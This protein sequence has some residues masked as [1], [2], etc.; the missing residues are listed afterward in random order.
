MTPD[1]FEATVGAPLETFHHQC[2]AASIAL[3]KS[4]V[5]GDGARVARGTCPGVGGQHSWVVLGDPYY[6]DVP[7]V[8]PTLWSYLDGAPELWEGRAHIRPHTP[9]GAGSIWDWGRPVAGDGPIIKLDGLSRDAE[10]FLQLLGPLDRRGWLN[11]FSAPVGG[12]PAA[13]V[14]AAAWQSDELGALV[15]ID[16]VGMLTD[17][18][19]SGLYLPDK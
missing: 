16:L 3:V 2:H 1:Q 12:W 10:L 9:H 19:P 14:Y 6:P 7:V 11:L 13:E 5:L 8:D 17:L 4:G 18:N 15:R